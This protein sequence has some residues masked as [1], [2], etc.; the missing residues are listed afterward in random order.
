MMH[1]L[2]LRSQRLGFHRATVMAQQELLHGVSLCWI[3]LATAASWHVHV[4]EW[5][6]CR[7]G[8]APATLI[9][10]HRCLQGTCSAAV[11][12]S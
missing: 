2:R 11:L 10:S 9:V 4:A 8:R 5:R 3:L 6:A 7:L 1:R 12:V